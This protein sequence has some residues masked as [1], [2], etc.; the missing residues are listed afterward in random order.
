[1][2]RAARPSPGRALPGMRFKFVA[3]I[4]AFRQKL[5]ANQHVLRK[6]HYIQRYGALILLGK[7]K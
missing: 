2:A 5:F 6:E 7:D 1:M 3:F 4:T